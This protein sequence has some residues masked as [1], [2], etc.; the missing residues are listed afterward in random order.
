MLLVLPGALTKGRMMPMDRAQ[1]KVSVLLPTYNRAHYIGAAIGSLLSQ[2]YKPFEIIVLDDGSTDG[3]AAACSQF[4]ERV[5]YVRIAR[6]GGKTAA[7]NTGLARARGD[8]IWIMDDDDFVLPAALSILLTQ[9][10]ADESLGFSFGALRKFS[11]D[12][13]GRIRFQEAAS[14][15]AGPGVLFAH[16]MEDCFITGQPCTLFRRS[17]LESLAPFDTSVLAS[18]DYNILLQ[19]ARFYPGADVGKVVLWQRQHGGARGPARLQYAAKDRVSRWRE[20]DQRLIGKLMERLELRE[21]LGLKDLREPLSP[22]QLRSALVQK[23]VIAGRKDLWAIALESLRD[24][25]A[26]DFDKPFEP[27]DLETLSRILGSRYGIDALLDDPG[28]QKDLA[29][30]A[31]D[32]AARR[33]VRIAI[34]SMLTFWTYRMLLKAAFD[35]AFLCIQAMVRIAGR[36]GAAIVIGRVAMRRLRGFDLPNLGIR[37]DRAAGYTAD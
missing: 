1:A 36:R 34:A 37:R 3:T 22:R 20:F 12:Q 14:R 24:A 33:E 28:L 18:V 21:Y 26:A 25:V 15:P 31:G 5:S 35:R 6:N 19:V 16:L 2:T 7:I 13:N 23:A 29:A 27:K 8:F 11:I 9:L 4:G 32:G 10:V 30:A 17:C